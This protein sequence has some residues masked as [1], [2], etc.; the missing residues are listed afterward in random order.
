MRAVVLGAS[1]VLFGSAA[2]S[3]DAQTAPKPAPTAT[4]NP[5]SYNGYIR[6][7]YFT[8]SN[9][10]QNA[11]NPNRTAFNIGGKLH[12]E[13]HFGDTPFTLGATYFGADPLGANGANPQFNP[14]VDNTLPGFDLNTLGEA[15]LQ[16]K[17]KF[18]QIKVGN[19][20]INT[21]WVNAS[22]SRLKPNAFQGVDASFAIGKGW[23]LGVDRMIRY[24]GRTASA[25]DKSTL[26][27][28]KPAGNPPY[29]IH[30]TNGFTLVD[31]GYKYG[32]QFA[33]S[34]N[35]YQFYD[36][37]N[38]LYVDGKYFPSPKSP[39]KPYVAAQFANERQSGAAY[40]GIVK[41]T[42]IG[43]Q[44][45]ASLN[46]N[47]DVSLGY[48]HSPGYIETAAVGSC[49]IA[50]Q[51]YFLP[52]GGTPNCVD[53]KN[54]SVTVYY[55]GIASP[56]TEAYAT[57]PL[58]TTSISQG[59]VDRHSAGDSYKLG[60]TLQTN[61][62]RIR[63]IL[64]EAFYDYG[65]GAGGNKTYEFDADGTYFLNKVPAGAYRGWSIRHRYADRRQPTLPFDFKYNRT[66]LEY[67]F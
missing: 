19:Q 40:L 60:T 3:A 8:R 16:Y 10:V 6:A 4:P 44:L 42:T 63:V 41:N 53:N 28:S 15:Y 67:D 50:N 14:R 52:T 39:I 12:G 43:M 33:S 2:V 21:P 56:Y 64:S 65:S 59:M 9:L 62:K 11:G 1:L 36:I 25:F 57:D 47:I 29:P 54:G 30:E 23:T 55:G 51:V 58:F 17:T 38:L 46:R 7:F 27:T 35:Y 49:A 34:V 48:D 5:F 32:S 13:Y 20:V 61:D 26:L 22:D 24:E 18:A 45:G 66:Q 37:A 31:L